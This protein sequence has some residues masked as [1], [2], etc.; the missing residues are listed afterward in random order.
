MR[1]FAGEDPQ[2]RI[3]ILG[4]GVPYRMTSKRL[5]KWNSRQCG[6]YEKFARAL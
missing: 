3:C 5:E 1:L 2:L 4:E 6:M